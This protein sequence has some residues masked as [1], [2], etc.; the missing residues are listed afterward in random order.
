[1]PTCQ[2]PP[3]Y[4][5][6]EQEP[7]PPRG[8]PYNSDKRKLCPFMLLGYALSP[9]AFIAYHILGYNTCVFFALFCW[10]SLTGKEDILIILSTLQ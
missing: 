4:R 3:Y 1:M 10:E 9:Y 6:E 2:V 7:L 5:D 8:L